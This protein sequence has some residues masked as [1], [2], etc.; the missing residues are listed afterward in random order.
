MVNGANIHHTPIVTAF[1]LMTLLVAVQ[2]GHVLH[3]TVVRVIVDGL[4]DY[5]MCWRRIAKNVDAT[6]H[7][8]ASTEDTD[9]TLVGRASVC[10]HH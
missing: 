7:L 9:S 10:V 2:T 6:H 8:H 5:V 4:V 3:K 1:R